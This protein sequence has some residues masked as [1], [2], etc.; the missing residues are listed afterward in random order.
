M[1]PRYKARIEEMTRE[2][3]P[4]DEI[5][6]RLTCLQEGVVQVGWSYGSDLNHRRVN[7]YPDGFRIYDLFDGPEIT[8]RP[9]GAELAA[10]ILETL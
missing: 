7:A 4:R 2:L 10:T 5:L 1:N 3:L 6:A 8:S 9:V